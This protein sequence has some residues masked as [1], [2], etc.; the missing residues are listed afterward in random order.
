FDAEDAETNGDDHERGARQHDHANADDEYRA[1]DDA[2]GD[3]FRHAI[4]DVERMLFVEHQKR[5]DDGSGRHSTQTGVTGP[6]SPAASRSQ[7]YPIGWIVSF[8]AVGIVQDIEVI[9]E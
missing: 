2:D 4:G 3:A 5:P 9:E 8:V 7:K 1:A 6:C